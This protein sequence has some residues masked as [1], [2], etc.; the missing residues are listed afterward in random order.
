MRLDHQV[1]LAARHLAQ[2]GCQFRG[3]AHIDIGA[4]IEAGR[5][6][7]APDVLYVERTAPDHMAGN[8]VFD[9]LAVQTRR[10]RHAANLA[11]ARNSVVSRQFHKNP[12]GAAQ[13]EVGV[14]NGPCCDVCDFHGLSSRT[15]FAMTLNR[16]TL[17]W[18][19][20]QESETAYVIEPP[21][22]F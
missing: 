22:N 15:K 14:S 12:I 17:R 4:L 1:A 9:H 13:I 7:D 11:I 16:V 6:Q 19:S 3:A 8:H 20:G 18:T 2:G 21:S 10:K 5:I